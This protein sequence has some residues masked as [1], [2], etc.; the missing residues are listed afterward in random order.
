MNVDK[1]SIL[2]GSDHAGFRLKEALKDKLINKGWTVIDKGTFSEESTDYPDYAHALAKDIQGKEGGLGVLI[3]GSANGVSMAANKHEGVRAAIAWNSELAELA[4]THNDANV[5]SLP[6]R[7][8]T[9][10]EAEEILAAFL[11]AEFEGGR[12]KRRVDKIDC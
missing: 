6:A 8:V 3:C 12:H 7:F 11:K 5:L 9:E 2:I 4:R 10:E 1:Q